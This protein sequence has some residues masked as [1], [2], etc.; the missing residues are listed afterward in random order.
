MS[1]TKSKFRTERRANNELQTLAAKENWA[2]FVL[3]G[4]KGVLVLVNPFI[5][6]HTRMDLKMAIE[7]AIWEIKQEQAAR[8]IMMPKRERKGKVLP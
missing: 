6:T 5:S 2:L 3:N 7:N 8:K 4:M 1:D